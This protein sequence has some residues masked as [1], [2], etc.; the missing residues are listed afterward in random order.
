MRENSIISSVVNMLLKA[1][2]FDFYVNSYGLIEM[3]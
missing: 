3:A 1:C 2:C